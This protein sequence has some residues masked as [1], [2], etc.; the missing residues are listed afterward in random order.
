MP[1][2]KDGCTALINGLKSEL[3]L[4]RD[5]ARRVS[6]ASCEIKDAMKLSAYP[7]EPGAHRNACRCDEPAAR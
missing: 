6:T 2:V 7:I 5:L 1:S 4:A 3:M